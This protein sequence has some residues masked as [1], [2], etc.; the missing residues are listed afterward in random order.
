MDGENKIL[1]SYIINFFARIFVII[2]FRF[3]FRYRLLSFVCVPTCLLCRS[4]ARYASPTNKRW[5]FNIS[6]CRFLEMC[7][8]GVQLS[9]N[10]K[11]IRK[12]F[13]C[14]TFNSALQIAML[15]PTTE[16]KSSAILLTTVSHLDPEPKVIDVASS[17]CKSTNL[18]FTVNTLTSK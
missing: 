4:E 8:F 12:K 5:D 10:V 3:D 13:V 9:T 1:N 6:L 16:T 17:G 11:L 15:V 2:A 14:S 7:T 18:K